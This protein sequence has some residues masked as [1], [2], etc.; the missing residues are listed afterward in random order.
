MS[1]LER[2]LY[3][4]LEEAADWIDHCGAQAGVD[5][6]LNEIEAALA[7]ARGEA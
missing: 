6:I 3:A 4:M 2:E 5:A 7:K 1:E